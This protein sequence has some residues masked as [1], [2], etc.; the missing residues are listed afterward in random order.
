MF[1]AKGTVIF[2]NPFD[3]FQK[4]PEKLEPLVLKEDSEFL[5]IQDDERC[6]WVDILVP[7]YGYCVVPRELFDRFIAKPST[8]TRA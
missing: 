5:V 4:A 2:I 8:G 3:D 1:L 7:C 6:R